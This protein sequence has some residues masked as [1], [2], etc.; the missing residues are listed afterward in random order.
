MIGVNIRLVC[1]I[2]KICPFFVKKTLLPIPDPPTSIVQIPPVA[3]LPD[4]GFQILF[5]DGRVL[6]VVFDDGTRQAGG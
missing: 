1:R 5:P 3:A 6:F 4:D 2:R